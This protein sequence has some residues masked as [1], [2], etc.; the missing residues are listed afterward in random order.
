[1][2]NLTTDQ[3]AIGVQAAFLGPGAKFDA[4]HSQD[5]TKH[6]GNLASVIQGTDVN[7]KQRNAGVF[8]FPTDTP[9]TTLAGA[10]ALGLSNWSEGTLLIYGA[11]S[12]LIKTSAA[13]ATDAWV[14]LT[15][16]AL[17]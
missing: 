10:T 14:K 13:G 7:K 15:G 16:T 9:P 5:A 8:Y 11:G 12:I 3:T 2:A 4:L 1:M 6:I 17:A